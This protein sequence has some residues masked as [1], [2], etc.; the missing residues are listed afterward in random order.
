MSILKLMILVYIEKY[1]KV[2]D[3]A[4]E[5]NIKQPSVTFHMK[6]LEEELGTAL[7]ES[8]RG[9]ML[10]TEAGKALYPYALKI[11]G[12]ASEA[13]KVVQ[14]YAALDKGTLHIGTDSIASISPLPEMINDFSKLHTGISI[15]VSVK[16]T[17][18]IKQMLI[19]Q[20]VDIAFYY[21][22]DASHNIQE[23]VQ[24]ETLF[25]DA[26]VVIFG[27][28]HPFAK[29]SII[30]VQQI[31]KE[32][33]IQHAEG[34]FIKDFT[35]DWSISNRIHLWER[36][37]MDSSEAIKLAV[38]AGDHISFYPKR[39]I[40]HELERSQ[41][42]YLPIPDQ[43]STSIQ[44]IMAFHPDATHSSLRSEFVEFARKYMS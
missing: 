13:K 24:T 25:K 22:L 29:L 23:P 32:F 27:P 16:P 15:Q 43:I 14:D 18:T 17:Q 39:G 5:L 34:T 41:L 7:F 19:N 37:Q 9:R 42:M 33:F 20:D 40:K 10:L 35:L 26:L 44:S 8:K 36:V 31:A 3:V 4:K 1:K 12:L 6:S 21:S 2:T 30:D 28:H 11:T 38:S